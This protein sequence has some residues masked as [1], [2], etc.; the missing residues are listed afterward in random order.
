MQIGYNNDV[1]YRGKTFHIQ[2]EDRGV[3]AGQIETQ[4]FHAGAILDT[5]IIS[6]E[7][8]V[9]GLEGDD[10]IAKIRDMMKAA[11]KNFYK[12]LH[13]G[14]YDSMVGL[15]PAGESVD[16]DVEDFDPG[17]DRVPQSAL[18]IEN[19]PDGFAIDDGM[20][21][22]DIS[23]LKNKLGG[24]GSAPTQMV[25]PSEI[26]QAMQED[27]RSAAAAASAPAAPAAKAAPAVDLPKTGALAWTGCE[28]PKNDTSIVEMVEAFAGG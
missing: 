17:Q 3:K 25:T 4:I 11:H 19:N 16:V 14:E 18:D 26:E 21:A 10:A 6:Y 13:S 24:E 12:K 7:K 8:S 5:A 28:A 20:E 22:V 1:E 23:Q 15:E 9:D 27:A 2:T